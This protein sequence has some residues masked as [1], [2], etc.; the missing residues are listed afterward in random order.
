MLRPDLDR[1][2]TPAP[3]ARRV[4]EACGATNVAKCLDTTCGDGSLLFA[5]RD[6]LPKVLCIGMDL[7][8]ATVERL[9]RKEPDW[10]LSRADALSCSSWRQ[11]EAGKHGVGSDLALLNPPFSMATG[12]G[13]RVT[14]PDF[15]GRCSVA[16]AHVLVALGRAA[17]TTCSAVVPESLMFSDLDAPARAHLSKG[18]ELRAVSGLRNCTFRGTR[19]N[20]LIVRFKRRDHPLV[21]E[22]KKTKAR[23]ASAS[24]VR[25]VRGGLPLFE[26]VSDAHGVRYLH[27]TEITA[28]VERTRLSRMRRVRPIPRGVV[29]GHVVLLPRVGVPVKG[30]VKAVSLGRRVQLS[31]CVM[32]LCFESRAGALEW[33]RA[34]NRRWRQL[35]A[36]YRGT[37]ARY[38]TVQ[39]LQ[40][41]L[42]SVEGDL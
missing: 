26:A 28:V 18:Y 24:S 29:S 11:A 40:S 32:A 15:A 7:D 13:I 22:G 38:T 16:M 9:R 21:T 30:S 37:G 20:A 8:R 25:L 12:K 6:V 27:S 5:A 17:P 14:L 41:W 4:V 36:L 1:Y 35:I 33:E 42:C 23:S 34:L 31:D 39:R 3:I 10:I 19:A 2:Y